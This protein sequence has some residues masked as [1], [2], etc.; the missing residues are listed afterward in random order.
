MNSIVQANDFTTYIK[1]LNECFKLNFYDLDEPLKVALRCVYQ[2][3]F[4]FVN[5]PKVFDK[6]HQLKEV[7]DL[8]KKYLK[9][10]KDFGQAGKK[11]IL[12][13]KEHE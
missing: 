7:D 11:G 5:R 3:F 2:A 6:L 10:N 12:S 8:H 4:A 13:V 9:V 1:L